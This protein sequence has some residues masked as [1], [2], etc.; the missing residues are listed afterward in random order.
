MLPFTTFVLTLLL[1]CGC[2]FEY[3]C[4]LLTPI[5]LIQILCSYIFH[6]LV[7]PTCVEYEKYFPF[8][9]FLFDKILFKV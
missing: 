6:K 3:L 4:W 9:M 1:S 2:L 5:A 8:W 7:F